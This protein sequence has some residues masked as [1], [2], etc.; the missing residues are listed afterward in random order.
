L[1]NTVRWL[2]QTAFRNHEWLRKRNH[3]R[4]FNLLKS[5]LKLNG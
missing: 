2:A 5:C 1:A 3:D 4:P